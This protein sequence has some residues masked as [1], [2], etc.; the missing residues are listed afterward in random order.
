[1]TRI[2]S[3]APDLDILG[4]RLLDREV[5]YWIITAEGLKV[6]DTLEQL[7]RIVATNM[8]I[9]ISGAM[10]RRDTQASVRRCVGE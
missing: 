8:M 3:R 5:G 10:I 7:D 9:A 6:G 2:A 4:Q 1:M